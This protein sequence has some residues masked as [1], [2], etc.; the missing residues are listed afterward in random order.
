MRKALL[1]EFIERNIKTSQIYFNLADTI[2]D[3]EY[4]SNF[5]S[6]PK[7]LNIEEK[8]GRQFIGAFYEDKNKVL[9]KK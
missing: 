7:G 2:T 8:S 5:A 1:K 4:Y 9:V 3:D 6:S